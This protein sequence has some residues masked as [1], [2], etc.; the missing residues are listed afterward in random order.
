[1]AQ[2]SYIRFVTDMRCLWGRWILTSP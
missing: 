1:M 2:S